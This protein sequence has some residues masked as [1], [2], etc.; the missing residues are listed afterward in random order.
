[1]LAVF[2]RPELES[3]GANGDLSYYETVVSKYGRTEDHT[4]QT[5]ALAELGVASEWRT[6]ASLLE[7]ADRIEKT[8]KPVGIGI[9]HHGHISGP[10]YGGHMILL[11]GTVRDLDGHLTGFLVSDPN[12]EL[13]LVNGGYGLSDSG[14]FLVYSYEN[15]AKRFEVDS[16]GYYT[17]GNCGWA[18]FI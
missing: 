11:Q 1:M 15:L 16:D 2:E 5:A 6:D 18:R 17:P 13:D 8:S 12:G 4:A 14:H 7:I 3:W 9:L 10:C